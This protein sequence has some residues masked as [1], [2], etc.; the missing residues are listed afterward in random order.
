[1]YHCIL[2][3]NEIGLWTHKRQPICRPYWRC[4]EILWSF[5]RN[6]SHQTASHGIQRLG[7]GVSE[8]AWNTCIDYSDV[9]MN[10]MTFRPL[11]GLFKRLFR[12]RSKKT[13]Q[14]CVTGLCV[15]NSPGTGEL[16]SPGT[17]E[18]PAQM[19]SDAENVSI[20]WRHH[21][22]HHRVGPGEKKTTHS[23]N[24]YHIRS[25]NG[26][27]FWWSRGSFCQQRL[28][29]PVWSLGHK[30]FIIVSICIHIINLWDVIAH[31]RP[32]FNNDLAKLTLKLGQGWVISPAPNK[33]CYFVS[34][35]LY[36]R[37]YIS[38]VFCQKGPTH[39][40][41]AWQ[42]GPFWQDT[43]DLWKRS[44]YSPISS[45]YSNTILCYVR[46]QGQ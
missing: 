21:V 22:F 35:S 9:I 6:W 39:H 42:I 18:F 7:K 44:Q 46:H 43:L 14:L 33:C 17:G 30:Y 32:Y 15:G 1:M 2:V 29:K 3:C 28:A 41:Y 40:A 20:W 11:D 16:N 4:R 45:V 12:R 8:M 38:M 31:S 25:R 27:F 19:A 37:S 26:T 10:A 13:S 34:R 24:L 5:G 36:W 23:V